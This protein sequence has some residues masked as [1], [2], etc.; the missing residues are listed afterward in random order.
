MERGSRKRFS[1]VGCEKMDRDGD[2][3]EKKCKDN[4]QQAKA[5]SGL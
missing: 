2:R 4:V 5:H 1:S 3:Q